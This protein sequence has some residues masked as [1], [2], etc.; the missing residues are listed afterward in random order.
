MKTG[1][2]GLLSGLER[3]AAIGLRHAMHREPELS[4]QE[5]KTQERII[6]ILKGF[7]ISG[8]RTFHGTGVYIDIQGLA[9]G[10]NR[11]VV[12]RGDID[13]LPIQEDR[14]DLLHRSQV[15]GVM[16]ACGH[17]M[18]GSIALGTALAFHRMR[19]N[20]S[21]R[22]RVIFQP[23]EEA[24]PLGGRTVAEEKLL[25]GFDAAVGFHVHTDIP[26]GAYGARAGAVTKSADQFTLE[27][28]GM[29]AH[30]AAPSAGVDAI[31]IA[32]AFVNEVQKVVSREMPADDGAIVTIG[33]IHGGEAT[34]IICPSVILTGTIR[35]SSP[36]RRGHLAR[37][38]REVAE[39]V[40]VLHR[41]RAEFTLQSGEPPVVNDDAM[42]E[43]FRRLVVQSVGERKYVER[44]AESGS[45]DFGF[46][47]ERLPSIYFWFGS[48]EPGNESGVHTP[49]FGASDDI[50]VPTAELAI[51]YC[52]ELLQ[53]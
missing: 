6:R 46:Y 21:G 9:S 39:G 24:E 41:G 42:V 8:A 28:I 30:G 13:A 49:S 37:R 45:D 18:H 26:A 32:G 27:L 17:D 51:R 23:A 12:L 31:S 19:E 36:E 43:R 44:Q 2:N 33:T 50:V 3:E 1:T 14:S 11:S 34:N 48:R 15:P 53:S 35:T 47:S 5:W 22:V 10:P 40:A 25:D 29:M 7:G 20:F 16:H 52:L 4:N 38:V